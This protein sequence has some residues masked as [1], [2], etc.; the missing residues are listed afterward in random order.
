MKMISKNKLMA[1]GAATTLLFVSACSSDDTTDAENNIDDQ[2]VEQVEQ[3]SE[4]AVD[5][6][7]L[8]SDADLTEQLEAEPGIESVMV[9]VESG[10]NESVNVDIEINEEQELSPEEVATK[11]SEV[12][13]EVHPDKKVDIIVIQDG[14]M[15]EQLTVE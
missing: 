10:S 9:Q 1:I 14:A 15:V 11:Y 3:D 12:I 5:V 8:E 6:S 13:K 7:S 2:E 4:E